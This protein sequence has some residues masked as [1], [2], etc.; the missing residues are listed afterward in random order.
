MSDSRKAVAIRNK[1]TDELQNKN[2]KGA[3]YAVITQQMKKWLGLTDKTKWLNNW[4]LIA[5]A[6]LRSIRAM[7]KLHLNSRLLAKV[8]CFAACKSI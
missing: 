1:F 6:E 8:I 4:K 3:D 7:Q 5:V 2:F